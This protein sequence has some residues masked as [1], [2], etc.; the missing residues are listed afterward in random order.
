[1]KSRSNY[2]TMGFDKSK[3]EFFNYHKN[4]QLKNDC[5]KKG[6]K[7]YSIQIM[8]ASYEDSYESID[9]LVGINLETT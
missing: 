3:L 7:G 1:M 9:S 4:D 2:K 5:L 6:I 8:V